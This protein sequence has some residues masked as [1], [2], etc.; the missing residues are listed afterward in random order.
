LIFLWVLY[1]LIFLASIFIYLKFSWGKEG[2][3][4]RGKVIM[5]TAYSI[6]FPLIPL[7]WLLIF[8]VDKYIEPL[9][10]EEFKWAI[11]YLITGSFILLSAIIIIKKR[12]T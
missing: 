5:H 6:V 11:W 2:N 4:E 12:R 7:V 1:Y 3:D 9:N 10:Y 8:L